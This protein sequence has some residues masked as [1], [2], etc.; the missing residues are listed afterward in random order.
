VRS[1]SV[2]VRNDGVIG[3]KF[4]FQATAIADGKEKEWD[5]NVV[6]YDG[7]KTWLY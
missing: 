4:R 6:W 7:K 3:H 1:G 2:R 5:K